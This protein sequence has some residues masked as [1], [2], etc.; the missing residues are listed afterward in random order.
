MRRKWNMSHC[1][2]EMW[3]RSESN[4]LRYHIWLNGINVMT[5]FYSYRRCCT[6][7]E[8]EDQRIFNDHWWP[9]FPKRYICY[10]WGFSWKYK[11]FFKI[12][13]G[14]CLPIVHISSH[15]L[16][17]GCCAMHMYYKSNHLHVF[18]LLPCTRR[19]ACTSYGKHMI[20]QLQL[21]CKI[22]WL[23]ACLTTGI[24]RICS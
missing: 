10:K 21:Y 4:H 13:L 17:R 5:G 8:G 14:N 1:T 22:S 2:F 6:W 12:C 9:V 20:I 24:I 7:E 23:C 3:M 16:V 18:Q 19:L 11:T 15:G